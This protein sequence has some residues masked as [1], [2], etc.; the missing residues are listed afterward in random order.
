MVLKRYSVRAKG[1]EA[2]HRHRKAL[3]GAEHCTHMP[4]LVPNGNCLSFLSG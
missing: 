2:T 4:D 3:N 1:V